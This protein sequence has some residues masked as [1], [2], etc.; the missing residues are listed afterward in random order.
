MGGRS[1]RSG[2]VNCYFKVFKGDCGDW[3]GIRGLERIEWFR[4]KRRLG[5]IVK[6]GVRR[7]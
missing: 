2:N 5:N 3:F 6:E 7:I 1:I 4:E